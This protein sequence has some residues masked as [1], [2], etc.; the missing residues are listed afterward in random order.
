MWLGS[1]WDVIIFE[2]L[3]KSMFKKKLSWTLSREHIFCIKQEIFTDRPWSP[4][5]FSPIGRGFKTSLCRMRSLLS[6]NDYVLT[7]LVY[8]PS[9]VTQLYS[10]TECFPGGGILC[11]EIEQFHMSIEFA[12]G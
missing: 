9:V 4:V 7:A 11:Y 10:M 5:R 8:S 2:P 12:D 6:A 3:L 1:F